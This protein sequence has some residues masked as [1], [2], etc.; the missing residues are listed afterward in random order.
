MVPAVGDPPDETAAIAALEAVG[1]T[2]A[3]TRMT[4]AALRR[5]A[6]EPG[7][8]AGL[9]A[10]T[11]SVAAPVLEEFLAGRLRV[12]ALGLGVTASPG[13]IVGPRVAGPGDERVVN[14]R[15]RAEHPALL[16]GS[17]AHD[18]LWSGEGA[19][20][21]EEVTLHALCALVHA[22][23]LARAP[24]L[25][26]TGTELARR[27]NSLAI[28]LLNSRHP[29]SAEVAVRA[30]DGPGTIPGGAP[31]M[32]TPDFW[33][34]P[35]VSGAPVEADAP[36]LVGRVLAR[37][38]GDDP[39]LPAPLRYDDALGVWWSDRGDS[40]RA[41]TRR[42]VARRVRARARRRAG[43]RAHEGAPVAGVVRAEPAHRRF[44]G[45][46]ERGGGAPAVDRHRSGRERGDRGRHRDVLEPRVR[47][48]AAAD[49]PSRRS[50]RRATRA[51]GRGRRDSGSRRRSAR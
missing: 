21:Y 42:A 14:E 33:S 22:Q 12:Q 29:G 19:G 25:A 2:D 34:I 50:R 26:A 48:A 15:Y 3:V 49:R 38:T 24:F 7:P 30:P 8:R 13:R 28:T 51:A 32:Q 31:G 45:R 36:A 47:G 35:F 23:L 17:L 5:R 40:W 37:V 1:I 20:Q 9:V 4:D 39:T 18:L 44:V 11:V 10:L 27:Q 6:P 46:R 43:R 16:A 41:P